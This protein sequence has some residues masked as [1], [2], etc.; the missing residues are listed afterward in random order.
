MTSARTSSGERWFVLGWVLGLALLA[1]SGTFVD[2]YR[3]HVLDEPLPHPYPWGGVG[4]MMAVFTGEVLVLYAVIR[5][6]TYARARSWW[7]A[8]AGLLVS[9]LLVFGFG[10]VLMHAPPYMFLHWLLLAVMALACLVL[11]GVSALSRLRGTSG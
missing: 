1:W 11:L 2:G 10:V 9:L 6:I 3:V 7:R 8:L 5:P 4:T